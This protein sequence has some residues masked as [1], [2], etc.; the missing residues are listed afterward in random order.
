MQH[1]F[2]AINRCDSVREIQAI[3]EAMEAQLIRETYY[4]FLKFD[5]IYSRLESDRSQE[6]AHKLHLYLN[7]KH[8][9]L[10]ARNFEAGSYK[11]CMSLAIV[12]AFSAELTAH[13]V[14]TILIILS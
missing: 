12:D 1:Q 7:Q 14:I 5:P 9:D 6:G 8:N 13:Q 2:Y 11:K 4:V 10:L 3:K